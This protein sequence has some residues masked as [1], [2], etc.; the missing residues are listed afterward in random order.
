[1]PK[2]SR[3]RIPEEQLDQLRSSHQAQLGALAERAY[4]A[5]QLAAVEAGRADALAR[6]DA[7]V[8]D[9]RHDLLMA[10]LRLSEM[11]GVEATATM[12]GTSLPELRRAVKETGR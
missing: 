7:E 8:A 10:D 2:P 6:L 12:T 3:R 4:C 1:M 9:A 11:I 5:Q